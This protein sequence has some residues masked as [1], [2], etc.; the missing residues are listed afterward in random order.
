MTHFHPSPYVS[1]PTPPETCGTHAYLLN[2]LLIAAR[3]ARPGP[4]KRIG[5]GIIVQGSRESTAGSQSVEVFV[6][7][8]GAQCDR[9]SKGGQCFT[10]TVPLST[11]E[12]GSAY[13]K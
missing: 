6:W 11:T 10:V 2:L 13:R 5:P 8:A 7:R 1:T 12:P 9:S 4:N 3:P